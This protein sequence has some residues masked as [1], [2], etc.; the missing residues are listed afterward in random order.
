[1]GGAD[2]QLKPCFWQ[3]GRPTL[4]ADLTLT[5]ARRIARIDS[6]LTGGHLRRAAVRGASGGE[7]GVWD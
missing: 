2:L 1:M 3:A 6:V 7:H 4:T 5:C